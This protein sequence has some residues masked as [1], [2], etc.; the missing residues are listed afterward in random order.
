ML[1]LASVAGAGGGVIGTAGF[2]AIVAQRLP[3]EAAGVAVGAGVAT[4]AGVLTT[5]GA[6]VDAGRAA[7]GGAM[8]AALGVNSLM[9][10]IL[11]FESWRL[12]NGVSILAAGKSNRLSKTT[13]SNGKSLMLLAYGTFSIKVTRG[14]V[15]SSSAAS[16]S[17]CTYLASLLQQSM[18]C[19]QW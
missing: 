12:S 18:I 5:A 19:R 13:D 4:G 17:S 11:M 1:E 9:S 10:P 16:V 8:T 14:C 7:T 15:C 3:G 2:A 6:V